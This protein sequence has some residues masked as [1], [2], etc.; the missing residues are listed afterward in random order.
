MAVQQLCGV[1]GHC[2]TLRRPMEASIRVG[3]VEQERPVYVA[4]IDD[5]CLLG[6]DYLLES[7]VCLYFGEMGMEVQGKEVPLLKAKASTQVEAAKTTCA[8]PRMGTWVSSN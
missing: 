7:I 2:T 5:P 8:S 3:P 4:D 1:S 6:L